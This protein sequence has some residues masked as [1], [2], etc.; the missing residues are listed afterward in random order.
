MKS[1]KPPKTEDQPQN[2]KAQYPK[3]LSPK[4]KPKT[5][6]KYEKHLGTERKEG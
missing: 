2:P 6:K 1:T 5:Q 3:T 4:P